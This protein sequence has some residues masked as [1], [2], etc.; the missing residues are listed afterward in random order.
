M[1]ALLAPHQSPNMSNY[2]Q[3]ETRA[4]LSK[5]AN[6]GCLLCSLVQQPPYFWKQLT[7][8]DQM[9]M[10]KKST[11]AAGTYNVFFLQTMMWNFPPYYNAIHM[12]ELPI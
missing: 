9:S 6:A 1:T 11:P 8:M 10:R 2:S 4:K 3:E 5:L 7:G 12:R